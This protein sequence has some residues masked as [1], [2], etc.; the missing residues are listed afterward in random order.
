VGKS[1]SGEKFRITSDRFFN[2][3]NAPNRFE[4]AAMEAIREG[5]GDVAEYHEVRGNKLFY[6]RKLVAG[7]GC[8]RCHDTPEKSPAVIRTKYAGTNGWGYKPGGLA[9]IISVAVP[10]MPQEASGLASTV[11]TQTWWAIAG[12]GCAVLLLLFWLQRMVIGA[13]KQLEQYAERIKK[14]DYGAVVE[15]AVLDAEELTSRNEMHRVS[16]GLKAVARALH[17]MQTKRQ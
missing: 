4:L 5:G 13:A 11:G 3:N 8:M 17:L 14:S 6:A 15:P 2:M 12:L 7:A 16:A 9:G 10:L 1:A